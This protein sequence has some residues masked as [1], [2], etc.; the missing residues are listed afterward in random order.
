M[1]INKTFVFVGL[2]LVGLLMVGLVSGA[3]YNVVVPSADPPADPDGSSPGGSAGVPTY[4]PTGE[5]LIEGYVVVLRN[6]YQVKFD[7]NDE[8]HTLNVNS[9]GT[10]GVNITVSSEPQTKTFSVGEEVKFELDGDNVYDFSVKLNSISGISAEFLMKSISEEVPEDG[11]VS[12]DEGSL[13][14]DVVKDVFGE[15][16]AGILDGKGNFWAWFGGVV[17]LLIVVS[18]AVVYF[19]K[20]KKK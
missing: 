7:I 14:G 19:K 4:Y 5:K 6:N 3:G 1:A 2:L 15:D 13:V 12:E 10:N 17:V 16:V 18:G 20:L 9:I 8:N 11:T